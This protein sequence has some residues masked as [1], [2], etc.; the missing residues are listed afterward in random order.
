MRF[1]KNQI[2]IGLTREIFQSFSVEEKNFWND[3]FIL[4]EEEIRAAKE[5]V[6]AMPFI[7]SE[8]LKK[9]YKQAI[10]KYDG[11]KYCHIRQL[12]TMFDF[13]IMVH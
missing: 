3:F 9:M 1:P 4:S 8:R 10:E 11:G 13:N 5:A 6:D 12:E 7:P 2:G